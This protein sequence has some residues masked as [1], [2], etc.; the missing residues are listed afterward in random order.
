MSG[1]LS[2]VCVWRA[3]SHL[4]FGCDCILLS[5]EDPARSQGILGVGKGSRL[6]LFKAE[7]GGKAPIQ[8]DSEGGVQAK[9]S[10]TRFIA[11]A[12][13]GLLP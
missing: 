5:I 1:A 3:D 7:G 4:P 13:D 8:V 12:V 2:S 10:K 6:R 11:P 9:E